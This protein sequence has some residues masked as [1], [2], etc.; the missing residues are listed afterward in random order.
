MVRAHWSLPD[1][2]PKTYRKRE[3]LTTTVDRH[4]YSLL[5]LVDFIGENFVWGS[6]QYISLWR[7]VEDDCIEITSNEQL[8]EWFEL[9]KDKMEVHIVGQI[10]DF[11]GP[12]QFSPT[13][14]RLHPTVRKL[15]STAPIDLD[16]F[17]DPTQSSQYTNELTKV[18]RKVQ[19][20][21]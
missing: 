19:M 18:H 3:T 20:M 11:E 2:G 7:A 6:K 15:P 12:L 8:S 17:I 13:K 4:D 10:N 21:Y 9:N 5:K 14:R 16:P 1:G